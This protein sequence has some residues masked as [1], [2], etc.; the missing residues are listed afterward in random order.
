MD[1]MTYFEFLEQLTHLNMAF[2]QYFVGG[3]KA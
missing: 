3:Y 2:I 1:K